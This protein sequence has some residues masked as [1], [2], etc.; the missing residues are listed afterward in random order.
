MTREAELRARDF[1]AVVLAGRPA[2][3]EV[4]VMQRLLAQAQL[5]LSS[6]ADPTW[7]SEDGWARFPSTL[8]N[9]IGTAPPGSDQQ[10]TLVNALTV[11]LLG[12]PELDALGGWLAGDGVPEGLAVDTDLRWRLLQAGWPGTASPK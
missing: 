2:E 1:V 5:A 11:A 9:L 10:L 4:G 8:M 7:A 3:T 12:K 6:Y